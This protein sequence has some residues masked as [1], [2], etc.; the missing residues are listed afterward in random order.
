MLFA[1]ISHDVTVTDVSNDFIS[2]INDGESLEG[3][4]KKPMRSVIINQLEV[5]RKKECKMTQQSNKIA[6]VT[7]GSRGLGQ[8]TEEELD[9]LYVV[10][11]KG[12]FFLGMDI[13]WV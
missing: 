3:N 6:I 11:F 1:D 10:H 9:N 8:T 2:F 4:S 5:Q 12:V 7:G 13:G